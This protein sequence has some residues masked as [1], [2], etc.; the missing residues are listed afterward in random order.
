MLTAEQ[1]HAIAIVSAM[2]RETGAYDYVD[3]SVEIR[4]YGEARDCFE[5]DRNGLPFCAVCGKESKNSYEAPCSECGS[6]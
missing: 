1:K 5:L 2:V 3:D 4:L 6:P